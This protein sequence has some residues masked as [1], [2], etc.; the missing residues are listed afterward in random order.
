MISI[1]LITL[2]TK[3]RLAKAL[4][5]RGSAHLHGHKLQRAE[6]TDN[7]TA[8]AENMQASGKPLVVIFSICE[9]SQQV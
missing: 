5:F 6:A 9:Q 2:V 8:A 4:G 3:I 1:C 7:L